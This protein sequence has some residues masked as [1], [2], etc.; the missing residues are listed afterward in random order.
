[1]VPLGL[2]LSGGPEYLRYPQRGPECCDYGFWATK[3]DYD[4]LHGLSETTAQIHEFWSHSWQTKLWLKYLC[5][6]FLNLVVEYATFNLFGVVESPDNPKGYPLVPLHT[7]QLRNNGLPAF[8]VGSLMAMV[9]FTI[10][11]TLYWPKIRVLRRL[12]VP[13]GAL[14]YYLALVLWRRRKRVFLDIACVNQSDDTL[15]APVHRSPN[16]KP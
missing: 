7:G 5:V 14:G 12:C 3:E 16:L 13:A 15:K 10:Y 9:V 6:L 1:M 11:A 8:I 4:K 2:L